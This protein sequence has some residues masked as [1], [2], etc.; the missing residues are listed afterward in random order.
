MLIKRHHNNKNKKKQKQGQIQ[1]K[2]KVLKKFD[3]AK[4]FAWYSIFSSNFRSI[5]LF[6][7]SAVVS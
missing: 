4:L 5:S 1:I 6:L 2:K 7:K 3:T